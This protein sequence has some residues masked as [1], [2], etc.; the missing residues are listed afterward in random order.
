[1]KHEQRSEQIVRRVAPTLRGEIE[2]AASSEGRSL[3]NNQMPNYLQKAL[4]P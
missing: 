4:Q 1:M 3:A 2:R